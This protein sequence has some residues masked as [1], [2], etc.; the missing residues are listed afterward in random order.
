MKILMLSMWYGDA[1]KHLADRAMHILSKVGVTRWVWSVRPASDCTHQM[2]DS[3]SSFVG[4]TADEVMIYLEGGRQ[5]EERIARLSDAGDRL[6]SAVEDEDYVLWYESDLYSLPD[7]AV[8][9]SELG[10]AAA[11][12]WPMLSHDE[13]FPSLGVRTPKRITLHE[14]IFYD[15]WGYRHEGMRFKNRPPYS[16]GYRPEP[17]RLDS[18]GSVVLIKADYIRAGAR[19]RGGGLVGLCESIREMGGE[20]WCDPRVP[21]VQPV[22]LWTLNND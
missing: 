16:A 15:T 19:M 8:R 17:F 2:L 7:V 5:A 6:L 9:L 10:A 11:G 1:A 13:R 21:V 20:V 3:V 12:G 18:V 14:S 4:K 22:E